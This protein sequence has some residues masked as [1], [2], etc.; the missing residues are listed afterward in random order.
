MTAFLTKRKNDV[1]LVAITCVIALAATAI[2]FTAADNEASANL[3][4]YI[5]GFVSVITLVWLVAAFRIQSVE[6]SL[7]RNELALQR[8]AV[9]QQAQET[10]NSAKLA[11]LSS[12]NEILKKAE[13]DI[14][15]N[16]AGIGKVSEIVP[17]LLQGMRLWEDVENSKDPLKVQKTYGE[18]LKIESV[19][20]LYLLRVASAMKL[21]FE[22]HR[23]D[24]SPDYTKPPEDFVYI[25]QTWINKAPFLSEHSGTAAFIGQHISIVM[26]GIERMLLAFMVAG[27]KLS[28]P[29]IFKDEALEEMR[30]KILERSS[31]LPAI[32]DPWPIKKEQQ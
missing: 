31:S 16:D 12:I 1:I 8:V 14:K 17:A 5:S 32:C 10:A 22:F 29:E 24:L 13:Q 23:R 30:D 9:E 25:Y 28:N 21:Y 18:W 19:A 6:L 15:D 20:R 3:A 11:S 26:P 27:A 7:Q 2:Y 4:T